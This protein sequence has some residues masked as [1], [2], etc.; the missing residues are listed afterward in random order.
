MTLLR[1]KAD[2]RELRWYFGFIVVLVVLMLAG[3]F[4]AAAT[5]VNKGDGLLLSVVIAG[6]AITLVR[7]AL[8][9]KAIRLRPIVPLAFL[10]GLV[11]D[12]WM[13]LSVIR[14]SAGGETASA[15][16]WLP[17]GAA[18]L[19]TVIAYGIAVAIVYRQQ[20]VTRTTGPVLFAIAFVGV[21]LTFCHVVFV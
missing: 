12:L 9:V 2:L 4:I 16:L 11:A 17:L 8:A 15:A 10:I 21:V 18:H 6:G 5:D 14:Y 1:P 19:V 13:F 20:A 7:L 3:S